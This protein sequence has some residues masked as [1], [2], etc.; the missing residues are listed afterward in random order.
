M[1]VDVTIDTDL[2]FECSFKFLLQIIDKL[3]Y[4]AVVFVVFLTVAYENVVFK[5]GVET[6][7][8]ISS[9]PES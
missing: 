1:R 7:Y 4:P 6:C 5:S 9:S 3:S 2:I 8:D